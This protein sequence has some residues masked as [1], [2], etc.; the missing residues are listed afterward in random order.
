MLRLSEV[1]VYEPDPCVRRVAFCARLKEPS[2][3]HRWGPVGLMLNP[4]LRTT[5]RV[6][7]GSGSTGRSRNGVVFKCAGLRTVSK[8]SSPPDQNQTRACGASR[9]ARASKSHQTTTDGA[10]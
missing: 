10:Q 1:I 9:S 5:W 7:R 3:H 2:D 8:G 6:Y 4:E